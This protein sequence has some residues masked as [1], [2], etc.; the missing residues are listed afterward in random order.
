MESLNFVHLRGNVGSVRTSPIGDGRVVC[1][2]NVAT[3]AIV[4]SRNNPTQN[5]EWADCVFFSSPRF[6]E[7][8]QI[9]VGAPV[10]I[11]GRLHNNVYTAADGQNRYNTEILIS[12]LILLPAG[13]RL[14][15]PVL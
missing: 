15:P 14:L 2:L 10:E 5:T 13:E 12:E 1:H 3:N 4:M 9:A 7:P 6:P 11:K 8:E